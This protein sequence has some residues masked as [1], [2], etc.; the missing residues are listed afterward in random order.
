LNRFQIEK[1]KYGGQ[2]VPPRLEIAIDDMN[3]EIA[4]TEARVREARTQLAALSSK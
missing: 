2:L 1:A 3:K 4:E